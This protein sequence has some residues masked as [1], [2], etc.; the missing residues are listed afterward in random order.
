MKIMSFLMCLLSAVS[1]SNVFADTTIP[2]AEQFLALN[3]ANCSAWESNNLI[4]PTDKSIRFAQGT[5][6]CLQHIGQD[7]SSPNQTITEFRQMYNRFYETYDQLKDI[8]SKVKLTL[9]FVKKVS[10]IHEVG[11]RIRPDGTYTLVFSYSYFFNVE[12]I[13]WNALKIMSGEE[14]DYFPTE[15]DFIKYGAA[16]EIPQK[17][18]ALADY[19]IHGEK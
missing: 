13:A 16:N 18:N 14:G 10:E 8:E 5:T 6:H 12:K 17:Y 19:V 3:A 7:N 15:K 1:A 4:A 2:E 9:L 11:V